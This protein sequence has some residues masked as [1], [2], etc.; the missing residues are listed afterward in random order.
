[1]AGV[2]IVTYQMVASGVGAVWQYR[3]ALSPCLSFSGS[4]SLFTDVQTD[5]EPFTV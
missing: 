1:M 2:Q 4:R 5:L 3:V